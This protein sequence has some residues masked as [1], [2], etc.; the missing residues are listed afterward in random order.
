MER[1]CDPS[2]LVTFEPEWMGTA[3]S[4]VSVPSKMEVMYSELQ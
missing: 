4:G 2:I 3:D 1:A